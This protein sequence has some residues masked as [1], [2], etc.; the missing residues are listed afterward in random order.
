MVAEAKWQELAQKHEARVKELEPLETKVVA[1]NEMVSGMLKD[2]IKDLGEAATKAIKALPDSMS[3]IDK[4]NW[5]NQNVE[6]FQ[7]TGDGV[8]TPRRPKS[9]PDKKASDVGHR[10]LRI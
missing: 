10:R 8:G 9:K 3:E 7:V 1:F 6:L 2:K 5:L 4:L